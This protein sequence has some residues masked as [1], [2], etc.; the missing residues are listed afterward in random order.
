MY[1]FTV[2]ISFVGCLQKVK[3]FQKLR[4]CD[5]FMSMKFMFYFTLDNEKAD[6][7]LSVDISKLD[8]QAFK[9]N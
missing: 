4:N 5:I 3:M 2:R 6:K 8:I 9:W 7:M 1:L